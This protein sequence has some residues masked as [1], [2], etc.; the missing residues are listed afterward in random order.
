MVTRGIR[1]ASKI[2]ITTAPSVTAVL[3]WLMI[4]MLTRNPTKM[5]PGTSKGLTRVKGFTSRCTRC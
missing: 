2:G 5:V 1:A 3:V 4:G